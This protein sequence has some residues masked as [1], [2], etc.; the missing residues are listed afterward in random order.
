MHSPECDTATVNSWAVSEVFGKNEGILS[1]LRQLVIV[2]S[3]L[4]LSINLWM[5][6]LTSICS[7]L[8]VSFLAGGGAVIFF[9][10]TL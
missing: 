8:M 2:S 3:Y 7:H 1:A 6:S 9:F 5:Y 10:Y 4:L